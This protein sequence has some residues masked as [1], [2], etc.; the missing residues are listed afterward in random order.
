M[1]DPYAGTPAAFILSPT[2][3]GWYWYLERDLPENLRNSDRLRQAKSLA[4]RTGDPSL[5]AERLKIILDWMWS[6]V[7]PSIRPLATK[8]GFCVEW[9]RML[10]YRSVDAAKT[11]E[12]AVLAALRADLWGP[13]SDLI[14]SAALAASGARRAAEAATLTGPW[15]KWP[16]KGDLTSALEVASGEAAGVASAAAASKAEWIAFDHVGLLLRLVAVGRPQSRA[17]S[18]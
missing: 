15:T 9:E 13:N 4:A 18:E 11:A 14:G 17:A 12:A 2:I 7:L 3:R 1:S 10:S 6:V 5:E 8:V 16:R